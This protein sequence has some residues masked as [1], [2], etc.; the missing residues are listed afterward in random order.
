[1][2]EDGDVYVYLYD[3]SQVTDAE[4]ESSG[5]VVLTMEYDPELVPGC[6][7]VIHVIDGGSG[8][9][10]PSSVGT[11]EIMDGSILNED[12]SDEVKDKILGDLTDE[13][14]E[15]WFEDEP[16]QEEG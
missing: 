3:Y 7:P 10:A 6:S 12:L 11:D 1:M 4:M 8:Q 14:M 16:E 13:E 5:D 15:D 2:G 9:P